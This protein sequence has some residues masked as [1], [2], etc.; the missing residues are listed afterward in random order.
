MLKSC[1]CVSALQCA[2]AAPLKQSGSFVCIALYSLPVFAEE[3][4]TDRNVTAPHSSIP[5][6]L[7][8]GFPV[9][10]SWVFWKNEAEACLFYFCGFLLPQRGPTFSVPYFFHLPHPGHS[11]R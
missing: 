6:P 8:G 11:L 1:G 2:H 10:P 9:Y 5:T 3:T 7:P 4:N